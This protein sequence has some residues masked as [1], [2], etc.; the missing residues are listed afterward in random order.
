MATINNDP[1]VHPGRTFQK[2]EYECSPKL[3]SPRRP[4]DVW[5]PPFGIHAAKWYVEIAGNKTKILVLMTARMSY[6]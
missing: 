3:N 5:L 2:A 1:T 4:T 6:R